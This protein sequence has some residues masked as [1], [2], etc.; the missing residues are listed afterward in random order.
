VDQIASV[1]ATKDN[2]DS[3]FLKVGLAIGDAR[4]KSAQ[5][6]FG[7]PFATITVDQ[8]GIIEAQA[9]Q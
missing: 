7:K 3:P 8:S 9:D 6:A 1:P 2:S 4:A 5:A